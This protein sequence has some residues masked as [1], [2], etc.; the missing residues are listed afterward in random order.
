[1]TLG[2]I[3]QTGYQLSLNNYPIFSEDY[4]ETLNQKII[5]HYFFREIGQETADRFNFFLGRKMNEIM[6]YYN[7]LYKSAMIKFDPLASRYYEFYEKHDKQAENKETLTGGTMGSESM[8]DNYSE[9]AT[10]T[11]DTTVK[12]TSDGTSQNLETKKEGTEG[13]KETEQ[14][15]HNTTVEDKTGSG[16]KTTTSNE[17]NSGTDTEA[18]EK[19]TTET[20][21]YPDR[22]TTE[23][24]GVGGET[25]NTGMG[26]YNA[27]TDSPN[28]ALPLQDVNVYFGDAGNVTGVNLGETAGYVATATVDTEKNYRDTTT[29]EQTNTTEQSGQEVTSNT[30][31]DT[32][33][34]SYGKQVDKN[35]KE[36]YNDSVN[37]NT[38]F[39]GNVT[40]T[41][42]YKENKTGETNTSGS[43]TENTTREE[44]FKSQNNTD[45]Q[46]NRIVRD[47]RINNQNTETSNNEKLEMQYQTKG[48]TEQSPSTLLQQ[49][50]DTFLNIDMLVIDQL[51][52]LFMGVF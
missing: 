35:D 15:T 50:R 1:M 44:N 6:P 27:F 11:T 14:V 39:D 18:L 10:R 51:E 42:N 28:T 29:K 38:Q 24:K 33:T 17:T 41:E 20:K 8:G 43:T 23:T 46:R 49:F 22:K 45:S 13:G 40:T 25:E 9:G 16:E 48:R 4:R 21:S 12:G 34:T 7:Q 3:L 26:H 30:G 47:N 32:N 5:D 31:S 2:E 52:P 19:G 36:A 37:T